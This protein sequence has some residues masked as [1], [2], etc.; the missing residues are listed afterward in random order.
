MTN[1][2]VYSSHKTNEYLLFTSK[3]WTY[4]V[5]CVP[6]WFNLFALNWC[7]CLAC[8]IKRRYGV[9]CVGANIAVYIIATWARSFTAIYAGFE[10]QVSECIS[11][12]PPPPHLH[13]YMHSATAKNSVC[14]HSVSRNCG[15]SFELQIDSLPGPFN[16]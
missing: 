4:T 3:P 13:T 10:P 1:S 7:Y 6:I 2:Y 11:F 8:V 16:I 12:R 9:A 14:L 15:I 5:S